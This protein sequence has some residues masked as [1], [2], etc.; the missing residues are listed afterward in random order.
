M[1]KSI[2]FLLVTFFIITSCKKSEINTSQNKQTVVMEHKQKD[3]QIIQGLFEKIT[4][5][6]RNNSL[7][8]FYDALDENAI[9]ID[10]EGNEIYNKSNIVTHFKSRLK[11]KDIKLTGWKLYELIVSDSLAISKADYQIT[12]LE[13]EKIIGDT[14]ANW[15]IVWKKNNAGDWLILR[16]IFNEKKK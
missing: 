14:D 2:V 7:S 16:E 4:N 5:G 15:H 1:K 12:Y 13:N 6:F 3:T 8:E 10:G 11:T 9:I